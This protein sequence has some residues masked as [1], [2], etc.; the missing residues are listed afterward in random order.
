MPGT[1]GARH[2]VA[3]LESEW[4]NE[5]EEAALY[6]QPINP[7]PNPLEQILVLAEDQR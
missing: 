5:H 2:R 3:F 7:A 4:A 6:L 1:E